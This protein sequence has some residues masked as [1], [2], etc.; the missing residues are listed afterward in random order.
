[1]TDLSTSNRSINANNIFEINRLGISDSFESG[2]SLTLGVDYKLDKIENSKEIENDLENKNKY[3]EFKLATVLTDKIENKI[4][5]S[6]TLDKKN[7]HLYGVIDNQLYDDLN[8]NYNFAIDNNLKTFEKHS[9]STALTINNFVTKFEYLEENGE[10][11]TNHSIANSTSYNFNNNNML[12][13]STRRNKKS[14][15]EFYNIMYQY[16]NDCLTAGI[17]FNK[18]FYQDA[19]LTPEENLFFTIT[20]IPLTTYERTIYQTTN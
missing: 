20:L 17:K 12:S 1:M 6:S 4:P 2:K 13:F 18:T 10:I 5:N 19:D 9:V 8:L 16:Q 15:T 3:L 11:G 14:F 7:S